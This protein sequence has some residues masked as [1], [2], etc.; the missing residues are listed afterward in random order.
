ML[1]SCFRNYPVA[2][3]ENM[4]FLP[5]LAREAKTECKFFSIFDL[6]P[7][8]EGKAYLVIIFPPSFVVS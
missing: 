8:L 1:F 2:I 3:S 6:F 4:K 7:F 5:R